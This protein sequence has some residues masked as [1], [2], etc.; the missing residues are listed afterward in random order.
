[1]DILDQL[2]INL[3]TDQLF[4]LNICLAFLMFGVALEIRMSDFKEIFKQPRAVITGLISQ[5]VLL[6]ALTFLL[7]IIIN[8]H[9]GIA[10]GMMLV[11]ACPGGNIS[12]F[13]VH[14]SDGNRALSVT[15]TSIT[16]IFAFFITPF[17]MIF[18]GSLYTPSREILQQF[19]L[20]PRD[21]LWILTQLVLIPLTLGMLTTAYFPE[22]TERIKK[23]VKWLSIAVFMGIVIGAILA[24]SDNLVK[25][26]QYVFL[27][28]LIH[29]GLAYFS[30][31]LL[32]RIS[33]LRARETRTIMIESGIQN[34]GLGLIIIFNFYDGMS[35]MALV[36]AWWAIWHLISGFSLAWWWHSRREKETFVG[37][38]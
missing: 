10:L 30:G 28:V 2:E 4:W 16:T 17:N 15:L 33:R 38:N 34:S 22:L 35:S 24:N 20:A 5:W 25:Y 26:L 23:Y 37:S 12:N 7:V 13:L 11:A 31:F 32:S 36:A 8:P 3:N 6:P 18:W 14:L 1:M 27:L 9:P 29:N 21:L 19:S